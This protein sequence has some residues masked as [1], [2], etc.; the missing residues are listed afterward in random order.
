M[1]ECY[2][3]VDAAAIVVWWTYQSKSYWT[4]WLSCTFQDQ[5]EHTTS[6]VDVC[7]LWKNCKYEFYVPQ[8]SPN[9]HAMNSL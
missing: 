7:I 4:G 6:Q 9:F 5:K 1:A 3:T 8:F 2:V